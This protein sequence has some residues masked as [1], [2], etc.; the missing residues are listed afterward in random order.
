MPKV[1][2]IA[3]RA[4]TYGTRRLKADDRF[5]TDGPTARLL[6][7][8]GRARVLTEDPGPKR[9]A[10]APRDPLDQDGD[11]RKGGSMKGEA[12]TRAK[13]KARAA[14]TPRRTAKAKAPRA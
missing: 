1:G 14:T 12:S 3:T 5:E 6:S 11:G 8:L 9:A 10:P 13:G 2:M 4:M 7:A